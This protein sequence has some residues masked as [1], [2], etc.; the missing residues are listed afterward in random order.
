MLWA[1]KQA[2]DINNIFRENSYAY[3][4]GRNLTEHVCGI[5]ILFHLEIPGGRRNGGFRKVKPLP[6]SSTIWQC[7]PPTN[8]RRC[9]VFLCTW[10]TQSNFGFLA[11]RVAIIGYKRKALDGIFSNDIRR[12]QLEIKLQ[13]LA[14]N[15]MG[16]SETAQ[17]T[18]SSDSVLGCVFTVRYY[19]PP[20]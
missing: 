15:N 14:Q 8:L 5:G 12:P 3:T 10:M 20:I 11:T 9:V 19:F 4:S 16:Y 1:V 6:K 17:R 13:F 18:M 7:F 2:T